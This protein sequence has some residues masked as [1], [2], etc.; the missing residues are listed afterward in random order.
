MHRLLA[1][2][3]GAAARV[4]LPT[5]R[6]TDVGLHPD[7]EQL[8]AGTFGGGAFLVPV[9]GGPPRRLET[10]WEG[11]VQMTG[12][13]A[14]DPSGRRAAAVPYDM[15]PS[16]RDPKLRALRLWELPSGEGKT[17]SL[18]HIFTDDYADNNTH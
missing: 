3:Y 9:A 6:S 4:L 11:A 18:A 8:L 16:I 14:I 13:V 1:A 17:F 12:G 15:S 7:G 10:G 5:E 2:V